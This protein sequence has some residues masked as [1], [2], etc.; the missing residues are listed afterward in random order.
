MEVNPNGRKSPVW[1]S[2]EKP[3][4]DCARPTIFY[5]RTGTC[6]QPWVKGLT[7][8]VDSLHNGYRMEDVWLHK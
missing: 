1:G 8:I 6:W 3:A 4:E 5:S 7:L 2:S